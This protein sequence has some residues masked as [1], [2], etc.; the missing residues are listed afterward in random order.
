[1]EILQDSLLVWSLALVAG[2]PLL[3]V[4]LTEVIERLDRRR[5]TLA[6]PMR[7]ARNL[8]L[9]SLALLLLLR[10]ILGYDERALIS[11]LVA[12][13]F[14]ITVIV[15]GFRLLRAV[16]APSGEQ[17]G[18]RDT[19]PS[20]VL[21]L[22]RFL[23]ALVVAYY[24]LAG[25]WNVN[26]GGLITALGVGSLVIALALQ[27]TLSNLFSGL[28]LLLSRPFH[29][30]DW[31]ETG[32]IEG[33]VEEVNW[34]TTLVRTRDDDIVV[35]PNGSMA[36]NT[37]T[38]YS[39]PTQLHRVREGFDLHRDNPPTRVHQTLK[40]AALATPR[41][42]AEPAPKVR[43]ISFDGI[44][45]HY[46]VFFWIADYGPVADIRSD[47]L[48]RVYYFARRSGL[49]WPVPERQLYHYDG[50]AT[51]AARA[52]TPEKLA[53]AFKTLPSFAVLSD[54]A[55]AS[56]AR[57][58]T[59]LDYGKDE[60]ILRA[61]G[62]ERGIYVL[63]AGRVSLSTAGQT[64]REREITQLA[65]GDFFG[66]TGLFSRPLSAVDV[67]ALTDVQLLLIPHN[68]MTEIINRHP[69]FAQEMSAIIEERKRLLRRAKSLEEP[70][71]RV[72][73]GN[74]P[75]PAT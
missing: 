53:Q 42:L 41:V 27:E 17:P 6:E 48:T 49:I 5:H 16:L 51:D 36:K 72:D 70:L 60:Q 12:T 69:R 38:N 24:I 55:I 64:G 13:L 43:T 23:L 52:T 44:S 56:L 62:Q 73:S 75:A 32:N 11:H 8:V 58:A 22:P 71:A 21:Q 33:Q 37:L 19:V 10:Y 14:W 4:L 2:I 46:D 50:P 57:A 31:I 54:E 67:V 47:F 39:R 66:E 34:R 1:M 35:I 28:L 26:V 61:K 45:V 18:W 40:A 7:Q 30:G 59:V 68:A 25:V 74:G 3:V 9:P 29:V 65:P 15:V 63:T 20:L